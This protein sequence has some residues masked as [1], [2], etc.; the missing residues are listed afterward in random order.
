MIRL[1]V[2][3][4]S[5]LMLGIALTLL[6]VVLAVILV[7]EVLAPETAEGAPAATIAPTEA[8]H[9][10][11]SGAVAAFAAAAPSQVDVV[12]GDRWGTPFSDA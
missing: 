9:A 4:A 12:F 3:R 11:S 10:N 8:A 1:K 5:S 6:A 2:I 7:S